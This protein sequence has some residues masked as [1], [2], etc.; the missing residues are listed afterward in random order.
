MEVS[1][2]KTSVSEKVERVIRDLREYDIDMSA[3]PE[4]LVLRSVQEYL[5][6]KEYRD[7]KLEKAKAEAHEMLSSLPSYGEAHKP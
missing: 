5:L 7:R 6:I 3:S 2:I 4:M 1:I